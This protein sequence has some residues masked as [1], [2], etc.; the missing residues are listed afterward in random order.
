MFAFQF[1]AILILI[2]FLS[3]A[4]ST[5]FRPRVLVNKLSEEKWRILFYIISPLNSENNN[6][7]FH[8]HLFLLFTADLQRLSSFST[9]HLGRGGIKVPVEKAG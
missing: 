2:P 9:G 4:Q 7:S 6:P 1:L 5:S 8:H 3:F